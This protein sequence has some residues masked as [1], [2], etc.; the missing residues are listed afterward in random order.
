[1]R[2]QRQKVKRERDT[3]SLEVEEHLPMEGDIYGD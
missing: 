2:D 3:M 1:M